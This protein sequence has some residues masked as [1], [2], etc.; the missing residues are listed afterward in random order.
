MAIYIKD[1]SQKIIGSI[2]ESGDGLSIQNASLKIIGNYKQSV[3]KTYDANGNFVGDG[4]LLTMLLG[5]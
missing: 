3:N 5:R 1:S 2:I 4:N